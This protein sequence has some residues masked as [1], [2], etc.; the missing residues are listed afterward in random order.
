MFSVED[1]N[2]TPLSLS[3]RIPFVGHRHTHLISEGIFSPWVL[4]TPFKAIALAPVNSRSDRNKLIAPAE[5]QGHRCSREAGRTTS[6]SKVRK[7]TNC[8]GIY[9]EKMN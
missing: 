4:L 7:R 9:Q 6:T 3:T 1:L 8:T 2:H 5:V